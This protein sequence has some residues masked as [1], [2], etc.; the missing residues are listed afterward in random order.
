MS[1]DEFDRLTHLRKYASDMDM[2]GTREILLAI[3]DYL[4]RKEN[5]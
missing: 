4:I 1:E 3:L 2:K 5:E